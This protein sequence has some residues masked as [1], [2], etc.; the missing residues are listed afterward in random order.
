MGLISSITSAAK[1]VFSDQWRDY[2]YCDSMDEDTLVK[3]GVKK[4][5][6]KS[7]DSE[8]ISNGS[9][10]VVNE[11]QCMMLV[12]Q[13][14][15]AEF[16][17][18]AGEFIYDSS[19]EPSIFYGQL[20][21]TIKK[22]WE[23]FKRRVGFGGKVSKEQRVYYF[24]IKDITGNKYGTAQPVPFRVVDTNIGLD[25][26]ISVRCFG[27]YSFRITDPILFY[28]NVCGNVT[29]TYTKDQLQNQL[30]SELLTA[31]QPSFAKLSEMGIRYSILPAHTAELC[32]VLNEFLSDRWG[33]HYGIRIQEI[34]MNSIKASDE[35]EAML[36]E[37]QKN[38]V[39]KDPT[40]AAAHLV[41]AQAQAMQSAAS[42]TG[43]GAMMAFAGM[44]AAA[45]TTGY[46]A[47]DLFQM[48]REKQQ[49]AAAAPTAAPKAEGW[50]CKSCGAEGN[51]GKF[52]A[53]CGQPKPVEPVAWVCECG[54]TNTGK[55]CTECGKPKPAPKASK[56]RCPS[57]GWTKEDAEKPVRFCP[58][59]GTAV[60]PVTE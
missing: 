21:Q 34:G 18:E 47:Q 5:G 19:S 54:A 13:G 9:I 4:N 20:D 2:Y 17:A 59:C 42:N 3:R 40:M 57:C 51:T 15:I 39:F 41:N 29:T 49:A 24:N 36:K 37:L 48:G 55:F 16:T 30:R 28:K 53:E 50:K 6:K 44:N 33:G 10:I 12:D 60:E 27:E 14:A 43:T 46:T 8:I 7:G 31:L 56:Y 1:G 25:M 58:E 32:D 11:G 38:A 35:D 22:T 26:D 45:G 52:C 23:S